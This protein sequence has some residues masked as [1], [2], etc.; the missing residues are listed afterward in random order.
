MTLAGLLD[1][2]EQNLKTLDTKTIETRA[3]HFVSSRPGMGVWRYKSATKLT[4][5]ALR[6]WLAKATATASRNRP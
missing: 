6:A 4:P 5:N 3:V 1:L 2:Y